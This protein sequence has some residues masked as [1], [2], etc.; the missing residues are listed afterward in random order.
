M[1]PLQRWLSQEEAAAY[2]RP[3]TAL[4]WLATTELSQRQQLE[5]LRAHWLPRLTGAEVRP[6]ALRIIRKALNSKKLVVERD[7]LLRLL[8]GSA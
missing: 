3:C 1:L 4:R 5:E 2:L 6:E 8:D 7:A